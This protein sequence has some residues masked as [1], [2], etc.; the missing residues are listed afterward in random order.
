MPPQVSKVAVIGTGLMGGSLCLALKKSGVAETVVGYDISFDI[1]KKAKKLKIA[2]QIAESSEEASKDSE[3][4]FLATPISSLEEACL[5]IGGSLRD[6]AVVSDIASAKLGVV[7]RLGKILPSKA[8]YVGGHPMTGSEQSG[9]EFARPDLYRD[10]HYVLTPT[11]KTDPDALG[12]LNGILSALGSK[13]IYMDPYT[14][15]EAMAVVSHVPHLLSVLLMDVAR[16]QH[17]KIPSLFAITA[18]GFRDMTRIAGSNPRIW[19]DILMEN[20]KFVIQRLEEFSARIS[21]LTE[22]LEGEKTEELEKM[23]R[24]AYEARHE[25]SKKAGFEMEELYILTL[26][27]EDRPGSIS[28]VSTVIGSLGINIEDLEITHS[29]EGGKG[30]LSLKITGEKNAEEARRKLES[31]GYGI[32]LKKA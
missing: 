27:V 26:M 9:V 12:L 28:R 1:R 10:V 30:V 11:E 31:L 19:V 8:R 17:E 32:S 16:I 25:F 3:V 4:V 14:H 5:D 13:V 23:L 7:E 6:G 29:T 20:R 2:D 24:S 21:G 22:I 15:D 18:G